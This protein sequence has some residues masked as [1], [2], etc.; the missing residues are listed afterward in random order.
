MRQHNHVYLTARRRHWKYEKIFLAQKEKRQQHKRETS[1]MVPQSESQMTS[2][3]ST[4]LA[5]TAEQTPLQMARINQDYRRNPGYHTTSSTA[6]SSPL[7]PHR[8]T[9]REP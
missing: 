6:L 9:P 7:S 5:P 3:N 1:N 2:S 4:Q 8:H